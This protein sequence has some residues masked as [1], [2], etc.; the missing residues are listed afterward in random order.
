MYVYYA[1]KLSCDSFLFSPTRVVVPA[2]PLRDV[3]LARK[4]LSDIHGAEWGRTFR[5]FFRVSRLSV[6][7]DGLFVLPKEINQVGV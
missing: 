4:K 6:H 7:S 1:K 2:T 3:K 5:V